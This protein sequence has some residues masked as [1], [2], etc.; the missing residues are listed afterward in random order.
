MYQRERLSLL[1][2]ALQKAIRWCEVNNARYFAQEII[3]EGQPGK[4]LRTLVTV[5]A[6][7]IGLADPGLVREVERCYNE[8]E[9]WEK[10]SKI[11]RKTAFEHEVAC[12]IIDRAVT[13][14]ALCYKSRLLPM[15]S[16]A[17]LWDIYQNE[18]FD[19]DLEG[20]KER[21]IETIHRGEEARAIYYAYIIK[22]VFES[23]DFIFEKV[24]NERRGYYLWE[25]FLFCFAK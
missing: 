21:F 10:E 3:K 17:V 15:F 8:F 16:F 2:S 1:R 25:L 4:V 24:K 22:E 20:Y 14:A 7:D 23:E 18:A 9:R 6:E 11:K 13:A 12:R 19:C 5:S